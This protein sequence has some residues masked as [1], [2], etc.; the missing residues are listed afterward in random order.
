MPDLVSPIDGNGMASLASGSAGTWPDVAFSEYCGEG[1]EEPLFMVRRNRWKFIFGKNDPPLLY[2]LESDPDELCNLAGTAETRDVEND[3]REEIY[4]QWN[5]AISRRRSSRASERDSSST[6]PWPW[7]GVLPGTGTRRRM[8]RAVMCVTRA[9]SREPTI[10]PGQQ[11][12]AH[13]ERP[14]RCSCL[15]RRLNPQGRGSR[16]GRHHSSP[17]HRPGS[18]GTIL[19]RNERRREKRFRKT[20]VLPGADIRSYRL[21]IMTGM[22]NHQI[23]RPAPCRVP[24]SRGSK[25]SA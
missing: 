10:R 22:P 23:V 11:G 24:S 6:R 25:L 21:S 16:P 12:R 19:L 5:P 2:D 4:R 18:C 7:A 17:A 1:T 20:P 3:L 9:T 14:G 13:P 15:L 8:L